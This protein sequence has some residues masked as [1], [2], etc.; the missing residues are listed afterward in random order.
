MKIYD[1]FGQVKI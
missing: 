1:N